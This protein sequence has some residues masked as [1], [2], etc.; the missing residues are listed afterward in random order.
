MAPLGLALPTRVGFGVRDQAPRLD[1]GVVEHLPRLRSR[2]GDGFVG[3]PLREQQRAVQHVFGLARTTSFGLRGL[4]AIGQLAEARVA[5]FDRGGGAL[6]EVVDLI[7]VV[8]THTVFDLG[9][10]E[11]SRG[12]LHARHRRPRSP[13]MGTP[14]RTFRTPARDPRELR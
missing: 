2:L 3:G 7:F 9:V 4:Q 8:A 11:L 10:A 13:P 12:D 5:L 14:L 1:V 6:E